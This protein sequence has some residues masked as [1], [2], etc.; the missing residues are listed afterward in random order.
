MARPR[1][2]NR[3]LPPGVI[4]KHGAYH[5]WKGGKSKKLPDDLPTC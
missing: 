4:F 1:K 2:Q 3:N 5:Y